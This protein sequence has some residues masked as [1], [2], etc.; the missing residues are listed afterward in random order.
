MKILEQVKSLREQG[1]N[2]GDAEARLWQDVMIQ[3]II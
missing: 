2:Q 1:Y 3:A